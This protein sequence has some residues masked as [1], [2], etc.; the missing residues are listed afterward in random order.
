MTKEEKRKALEIM[1]KSAPDIMSAR[2][3]S[4]WSPLGKNHVYELIHKGELCAFNYR[5]SY[6]IAK[7]DLIDYLLAHSD[8]PPVHPSGTG[9]KKKTKQ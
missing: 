8:D 7:V 4:H 2:Q 9:R 1:L 3:A 5:S 6:I